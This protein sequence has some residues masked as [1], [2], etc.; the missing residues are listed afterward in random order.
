MMEYRQK[1]TIEAFKYDG[2]LKDFQGNYYAPAWML[3]APYFFAGQGDLFIHSGDEI[4]E[5]VPG[6]YIIHIGDG[7]VRRCKAD[8]FEATYEAVEDGE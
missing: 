1:T 6:D 8:V 3:D 2:D 4:K 5:V 7:N